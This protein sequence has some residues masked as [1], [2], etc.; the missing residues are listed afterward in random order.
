M[1][2]ITIFGIIVVLVLGTAYL[3][4]PFLK[5]NSKPKYWEI[6]YEQPVSPRLK[7]TLNGRGKGV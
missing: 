7:D 6:G 3:A 1:K 2:N 4:L 5:L